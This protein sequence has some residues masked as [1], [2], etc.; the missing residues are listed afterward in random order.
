MTKDELIKENRRLKRNLASAL[1]SIAQLT[2]APV[3]PI[4]PNMPYHPN[5]LQPIG[6]GLLEDPYVTNPNTWVSYSH[7]LSIGCDGPV[8][9]SAVK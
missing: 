1:K 2:A 7:D 4:F 3:Q 5:P 6:P 9:L 8:S